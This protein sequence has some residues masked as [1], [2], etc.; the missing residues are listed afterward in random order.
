MEKR[1]HQVLSVGTS[2]LEDRLKTGAN[3]S[4]QTPLKFSLV[5]ER[6]RPAVQQQD[7]V[8]KDDS[9]KKTY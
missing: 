1:K 9:N 8:D 6:N 3:D 5:R 7:V 4:R 2:N